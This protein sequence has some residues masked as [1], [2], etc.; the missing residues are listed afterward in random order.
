MGFKDDFT[1]EEREKES[2][3]IM[4]KY[5]SRIPIVVEKYKSCT[6]NDIDK[7]KYLVPKELNMNSFIYVIR[8]RI[9]LEPSESIF[10]MID[11]Q[12][13][14]SNT[15]L[16]QVYETFAN[17]DGFLYITYTSENTFG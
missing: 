1:F 15:P 7:K 4:K 14:P 11:N 2:T 9:K 3:K 10:V 12:L 13:C 5:P 16:N 17:K 6:L 8:K